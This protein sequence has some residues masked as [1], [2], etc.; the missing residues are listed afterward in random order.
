[1][2]LLFTREI[3]RL[4]SPF[5]PRPVVRL[6]ALAVAL[7]SGCSTVGLNLPFE[8]APVAPDGLRLKPSLGWLTTHPVSDPSAT[9]DGSISLRTTRIGSRTVWE[10]VRRV[11]TD[12]GEFADS[13]LL[14]KE[15]LRPIQTW[16]W[17]PR[18]TYIVR[19][20]HRAVEREFQ[21]VAGQP[22][23]WSEILEVEP[24]S[25]LGAELIVATLPMG[26]G[27][28]GMVPVT[29]DTLERGWAWMKYTVQREIDVAERANARPVTMWVIDL[30]MS[31]ERS[32][33]WIATEGKSIRR[34]EQLGP[35]NEVLSTV[36]RMLL[37]GP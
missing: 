1:V 3:Q 7:L 32:R 36:R 16:R 5:R 26:E 12:Q 21:P 10:Q 30:E 37:G 6:A 14:D 34:I 18:G 8:G 35:N 19:Y 33:V 28:T 25:A 9:P 31:G 2:W 17:T 15:T 22:S 20:N 11:V 13:I 29:V 23:R 24:Y 27:Q 4:N